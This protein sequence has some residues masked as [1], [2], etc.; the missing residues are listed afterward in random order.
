MLANVA[1][2]QHQ[3]Q[4]KVRDKISKL[5]LALLMNRLPVFVDHHLL[6]YFLQHVKLMIEHL[7]LDV[8]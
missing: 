5:L 4:A 6:R 3:E 1:V 2:H 7:I 8:Y